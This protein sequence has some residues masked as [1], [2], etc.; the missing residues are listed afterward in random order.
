[1]PLLASDDVAHSEAPPADKI[2]HEEKV[3]KEKGHHRGHGKVSQAH[4]NETNA[5]TERLN[6]R[7]LGHGCH[8]STLMP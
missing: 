7:C 2:V 4:L 6:K 1:M 5:E 3:E 8:C